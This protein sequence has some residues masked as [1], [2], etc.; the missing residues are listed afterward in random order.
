MFIAALNF[1]V[2]QVSCHQLKRNS[3]FINGFMQK[4]LYMEAVIGHSYIR[5]RGTDNTPIVVDKS[6]VNSWI[7][8]RLDIRIFSS[9]LITSSDLVPSIIATIVPFL[10]CPLGLVTFVYSSLQFRQVSPMHKLVS[11]FCLKSNYFQAWSNW[12][13]GL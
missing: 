9:T 1:I 7:N 11:I 2:F 10:P 6:K 4:K 12:S 13:Q 3:K 8:F 5:E